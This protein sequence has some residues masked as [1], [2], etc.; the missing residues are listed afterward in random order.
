MGEA[1][2][3]SAHFCLYRH[4]PPKIS[5]SLSPLTLSAYPM[6]SRGRTPSPSCYSGEDT[7]NI[8]VL[9]PSMALPTDE[10]TASTRVIWTWPKMPNCFV[11]STIRSLATIRIHRRNL[12]I[13]MYGYLPDISSLKGNSTQ[14]RYQQSLIP[15]RIVVPALFHLVS[16]YLMNRARFKRLIIL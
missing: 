5:A 9:C 2:E 16:P 14:I 6:L 1:G 12:S 13:I 7:W 3:Q 10:C 4:L 11:R 15:D 8:F